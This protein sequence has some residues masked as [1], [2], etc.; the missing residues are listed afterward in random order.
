MSRTKAAETAERSIHTREVALRVPEPHGLLRAFLAVPEG[1]PWK[2]AVIVVD[3]AP[4]IGA[5]ISELCRALARRG[6]AAVAPDLLT[7]RPG[8]AGLMSAWTT[9]VDAALAFLRAEAP[10][11]PPRF[12]IVGFGVGG[13]VALS[14]GYRCRIGA[15][16]SF[17]GDAVTRLRSDL[18]ILDGPKPH[19]ASLLCLVGA[20]DESVRLEDLAIV[21]ERL[22]GFRMQHSF[23]VYPR[24]KSNF[25]FPGAREHRPAAAE[26]AWNRLL[27]VLETAPRL[28]Y[29]FA[30]KR[31]LGA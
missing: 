31:A 6:H 26:D 19:A 5:H 18:G 23:V 13:F 28:R 16:V 15:A 25:F 20:E 9:G 11:P 14:A 10:R 17:Y 29:R 2:S 8:D 3:D 24:T 1:A 12:G 21:R 4:G 27:H 22:A 30:K 7:L